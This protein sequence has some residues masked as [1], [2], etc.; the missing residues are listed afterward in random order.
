MG[1]V[2]SFKGKGCYAVNAKKT[3]LAAEAKWPKPRIAAITNTLDQSNNTE[4]HPIRFTV[5]G[6]PAV[7][8]KLFAAASKYYIWSK[9]GGF[10]DI[11]ESK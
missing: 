7:Q 10:I 2:Q 4:K 9:T 1:D 3:H 5:Y 11:S 6:T 8:S